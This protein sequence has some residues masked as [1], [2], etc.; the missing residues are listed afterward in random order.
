MKYT[1]AIEIK[2]L[3]NVMQK[4]MQTYPF[5]TGPDE[6]VNIECLREIK[7]SVILRTIKHRDNL[8]ILNGSALRGL[9]DVEKD[10]ARNL[11]RLANVREHKYKD[12][13]KD[14][15]WRVARITRDRKNILSIG[16]GNGDELIFIKAL[17]PN[18]SITA[19][20][21]VDKVYPIVK[22]KLNVK[23]IQGDIN[24]IINELSDKYDLIFC[25][26]V[27]EHSYEPDKLIK[28]LYNL[29]SEDGLFV[30]GLPMDGSEEGIFYEQ[31]CSMAMDTNNINEMNLILFDCGHPWKTN[32]SDL[33]S[34]MEYC[35]FNMID[36]YQRE[37]LFTRGRSRKKN[38]V[39]WTIGKYLNNIFC[40]SGHILLNHI[41]LGPV[42]LIIRKIYFSIERR[43]W[44]GTNNLKNYFSPDVV[45]VAKK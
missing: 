43:L 24:E 2:I 14:Y 37:D 1:K 32:A 7:K 42:P 6:K 16:C 10:R 8:S 26:H 41:Y 45:V 3:N 29:L 9:D 17:L 15:E 28:T 27:L 18:S 4:Y 22:D 20:D 11:F 13:L 33:V 35:G 25:N 34:T 39:K 31:I 40:K 19:I 21:Y 36:I 5:A 23:F 44:F 30:A 38:L 12:I